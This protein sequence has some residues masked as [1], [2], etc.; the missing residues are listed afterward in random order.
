MIIGNNPAKRGGVIASVKA[1]LTASCHGLLKSIV[2]SNYIK[3]YPVL[4]PILRL[5]VHWGDVT[6]IAGHGVEAGIKS[7]MLVFL[8][9]IFCVSK[10]LIENFDLMQVWKQ[11][12]Q[13]STGQIKDLDFLQQWEGV[14]ASLQ[15]KVTQLKGNENTPITLRD[16]QI[17][18]ILLTFF[19]EYNAI[20]DME[21]PHTFASLLGV[22]KLAELLDPD[23]LR[24]LKEH[25]QRAFHLLALYRDAEVLLTVSASEIDRL[26]FLSETLS[27]AMAGSER[28]NASQLSKKT[29][30]K[31]TIRPSLPGS[32]FG[33]ILQAIGTEFAVA[34]V[35]RALSTMA[36]Q[37]LRNKAVIMSVCFVKE[38]KQ[39]LFEGILK[40]KY[41]HTSF[42]NSK[43]FLSPFLLL[44]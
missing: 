42:R 1:D 40:Q 32:A 29:G 6:G 36:T 39:M 7:T 24:Q 2:L 14:I 10:G 15:S 17:G 3:S 9:L 41:Y 38:A 27:Y 19:Q 30:A 4:L 18:E 5:L 26:F 43:I 35:E 37:A 12:F 13:I 8:M 34:A 31:V 16:Q 23:H 44:I 22:S 20:L 25:M 28:H 33:L 21:I 11:C